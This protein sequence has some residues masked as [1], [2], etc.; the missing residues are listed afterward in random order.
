[1]RPKKKLNFI[2]LLICLLHFMFVCL[3]QL[4]GGN[5][6]LAERLEGQRQLVGLSEC[7][8]N[9][10]HFPQHPKWNFSLLK[11]FSEQ[12]FYEQKSRRCLLCGVLWLCV[13]VYQNIKKFSDLCSHLIYFISVCA[14]TKNAK[15]SGILLSVPSIFSARGNFQKLIFGNSPLYIPL[16]TK[17][18]D[19]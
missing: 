11:T 7:R 9:L 17:Q 16:S 8:L 19:S 6:M 13:R 10:N 12:T 15:K 18:R 4:R 5:L 2:C 1:M 3:S 14:K